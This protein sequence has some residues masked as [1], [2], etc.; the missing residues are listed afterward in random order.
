MGQ[1]GVVGGGGGV[2][3]V[4]KT[5]VGWERVGCRLHYILHKRVKDQMI[6]YIMCGK[7]LII[8]S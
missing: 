2:T 4:M 1:Y 6:Q 8:Y 7:I 3:V 5:G